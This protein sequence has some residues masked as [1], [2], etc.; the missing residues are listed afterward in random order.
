MS[1]RHHLKL[2]LWNFAK[3]LYS[4]RLQRLRRKCTDAGL[5]N[6]LPHQPTY[7]QNAMLPKATIHTAK[8][9]HMIEQFFPICQ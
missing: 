3:G 2:V 6:T 5:R 9:P 4:V 7:C 8:G 1:D